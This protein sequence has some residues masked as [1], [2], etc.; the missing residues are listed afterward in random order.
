[1]LLRSMLFIPGDSEK[2]LAKA[3]DIAADALIIDLE[4]S[5]AGARKE[6][7]RALTA[8]FLKARSAAARKSKLFVRINPLESDA[9]MRDLEIIMA[10][11]PRWYRIAEGH[12]SRGNCRHRAKP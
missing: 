7:G 4:D 2:K 11:A 9:P 5:V 1:M 6:A 12:G 10:G 8:D 3:D